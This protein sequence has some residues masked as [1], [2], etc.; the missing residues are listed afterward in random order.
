MLFRT[1]GGPLSTVYTD[2]QVGVTWSPEQ[3]PV[4]P[5]YLRGVR[6]SLT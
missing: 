3:R 6:R 2:D 4:V 5:E 1:E